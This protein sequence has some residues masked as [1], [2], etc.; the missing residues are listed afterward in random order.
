MT[1]FSSNQFGRLKMIERENGTSCKRL[2]LSQQTWTEIPHGRVYTVPLKG[3][4]P[5]GMT[6]YCDRRV[7]CDY[8]Y[9]VI[10]CGTPEMRCVPLEPNDKFQ[11]EWQE[12]QKRMEELLGG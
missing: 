6:S 7:F 11:M 3:P 5:T 12:M 10:C 9:K 4:N 8:G 2:M 1:Q